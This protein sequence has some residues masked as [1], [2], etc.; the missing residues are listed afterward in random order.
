MFLYELLLSLWC[1]PTLV[2]HYFQ[3]SFNLKVKFFVHVQNN[4]MIELL[5]LIITFIYAFDYS[6]ERDFCFSDNKLYLMSSSM[7]KV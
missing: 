7:C 1:F 6:A 3:V 4:S 2:S 5:L